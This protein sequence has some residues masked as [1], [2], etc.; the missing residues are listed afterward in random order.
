MDAGRFAQAMAHVKQ[1]NKHR[2]VREWDQAIQECA[3][4]INLL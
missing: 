2:R 4:A 3:V 1:A